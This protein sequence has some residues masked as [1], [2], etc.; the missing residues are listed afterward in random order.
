[1]KTCVF[2]IKEDPVKILAEK[3]QFIK[4]EFPIKELIQVRVPEI[5]LRRLRPQES[6]V[7]I[8]IPSPATSLCL[9]FSPCWNKNKAYN[10]RLVLF[11]IFKNI[12]L[13]RVR[14]SLLSSRP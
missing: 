13:S 14:F 7:I 8:S 1:M 5:V 12:E 6:D 2:D 4:G 9:A 3:S 10:N 11:R